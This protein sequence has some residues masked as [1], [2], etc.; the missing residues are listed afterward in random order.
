MK[1]KRFVEALEKIT[2]S[3]GLSRKI[4]LLTVLP[5]LTITVV[6]MVFIHSSANR[7]SKYVAK[8]QLISVAGMIGIMDAPDEASIKA[9]AE[10]YNLKAAVYK[11]GNAVVKDGISGGTLSSDISGKAAKEPYQTT[12]KLGGSEYLVC[13]LTASNG[14]VIKVS[15]PVAR[16]SKTANLAFT[17]NAI[18]MIF[19]LLICIAPVILASRNLA[20][21]LGIT[22]GQIAEVANG[23][24]SVE[25]DEKVA[26][27]NDELGTVERSIKKLADHFRK[28]I[29]NIDETSTSLG[30]IS[31]DF[32][33]SFETVVESI[34]NVNIAMEEIAKGASS[35]ASESANLN[36]SFVSIG[37]S[38]EAAGKSV[39]MLAH[40]AETMKEYNKTAQ[41]T[42]FEIEKMSTETNR[43]VQEIKE[44]T[45]KTNKS[46]LQIR[47]ATDMIA[48]IA[49]QTNLLSLNASIEAARAGESGRG[50]AVV[51]DEIRSLADQSKQSAQDI[52]NIV[53]E[54]IE[55]SNIA[56]EAMENASEIMRKQ[57][58]GITT[59][60]EVFTKLNG[61]IDSVVDAVDVITDEIKTLGSD[62]NDAMSGMGSLAA[63][64]EENAASTWET[65]ASMNTLKDVVIRGKANTD[66]IMNLSKALKSETEKIQFE[67]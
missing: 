14:N 16:A 34:E 19:L 55:N 67:R 28:L 21:A 32:S 20:K 33:K 54:L 49:S 47:S 48:D 1:E 40:S 7:C 65:S 42:I 51:A 11:N 41:Q 53:K 30:M 36:S 43:S 5:I 13:Y 57:S 38:I 3:G 4:I 59:S 37:D 46:A 39:E 35:Q 17:T 58:E 6:G 64:A 62:K 22:L 26:A 10:K 66:E 24:L 63:I 61:E 31:T 45:S 29:G 12:E 18:L 56:V 27:R 60:K 44:Q 2:G 23:N 8:E 25:V 9:V 50:F 15:T 52:A